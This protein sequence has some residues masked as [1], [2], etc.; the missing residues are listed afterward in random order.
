MANKFQKVFSQIFQFPINLIDDTCICADEVL[1]T[2]MK[3]FVRVLTHP[4]HL[5]VRPQLKMVVADIIAGRG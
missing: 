4:A 5:D 3:K 2:A 1:K